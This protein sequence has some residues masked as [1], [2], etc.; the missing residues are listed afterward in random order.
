M[1]LE[2]EDFLFEESIDKVIKVLHP[3]AKQKGLRLSSYIEPNVCP[4][5]KADSLRIEQ[6]LFNLVGN[7][8]KFTSKG[9][10]ELKCEVIADYSNFQKIQLKVSDTGIGMDKKYTETIFKKFSQE[11]KAV[12]RKFGGTGLG[13]A[14]T[15]ELVNLMHGDITIESEKGVGTTF[16]LPFL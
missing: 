15:K 6:I 2:K 4:V 1:E 8:L 16:L 3:L 9:K 10:I 12:T 7:S 13:M 14:I 5:L 11:D